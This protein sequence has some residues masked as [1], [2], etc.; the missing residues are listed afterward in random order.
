MTTEAD[1]CRK[2]VLPKL[3]DSD[4]NDDQISEQRYFTDGRIVPVGKGHVRKAGKRVDYLLRYHPDF[5]IAVVEAKAAYKKPGDGL[6]A[7]VDELAAL[8]DATQTELDALL[9]SVLDKAFR[10]EL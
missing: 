2:Y 8:Q 5:P 7:Q 9:P 4:W 6:Q 10:G 1:T 3:Y